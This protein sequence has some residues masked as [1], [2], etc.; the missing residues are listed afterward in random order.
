MQARSLK[1]CKKAEVKNIDY[2]VTIINRGGSIVIFTPHGGGIER[3]ISELVNAIAGNNLSYYLFEGL[4]CKAKDSH[5]MH[6]KSTKYDEFRSLEMVRKF[7]T[8][9]AI[10]GCDDKKPII[11]VGGKD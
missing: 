6:I 11:Y 7:E 9:L 10:H 3:G 5:K 8:A 2:R 1:N 4:M